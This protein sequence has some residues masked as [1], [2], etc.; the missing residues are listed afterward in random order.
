MSGAPG[1]A[2]LRV[3]RFTPLRPLKSL[4]YRSFHG[5]GCTPVAPFSKGIE[6]VV[7]GMKER[8]FYIDESGRRK[9]PCFRQCCDLAPLITQLNHHVPT[10]NRAT[11]AE[12]LATRT[13]SKRVVYERAKRDL[14]DKAAT[15]AGLAK[16][17]FFTKWESTIW[18]KKQVPRIVS[19]RDPR[20]NYLL[21]RYLLP[22][23]HHLYDAMGQLFMG[24]PVIAKGMTQEAK[25]EAIAAK[26]RP[27]WVAVGLDASRFDQTIGAELLK[28]EHMI[29]KSAYP[30]DRLLANLL[31]EQLRNKGTAYCRDG[32]VHADIG[33]MR[34]SGDQNTSLG[35]CMIS[36][37]LAK[38]YFLEHGFE[39]DVLNDGDDLIMF[40]HKSNLH[41]LQDLGDW[42]LQWGLRMKVEEP[43]YS[44]EQ[45]EFCQSKPVWT[46][47]GYKLVRNP[48]KAFNTD[49]SGGNRLESYDNYRVHLRS[50]GVCGLSM[51]AGIP[52]FQEFYA[53]GIHLGKTGKFT[54]D[55]AGLGYQH[56]IQV[57]AGFL[58][59]KQP[60]D[61]RTRESF[62]QAFGI[63]AGQQ[64]EI[65]DAI[66]KMV[67]GRPSVSTTITLETQPIIFNT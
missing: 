29:Y 24:E 48:R 41:H 13:G 12:F 46:P 44:P 59:R 56:E 33:A 49:Y 25:G 57:R 34:C 47:T 40:L 1:H 7:S 4:Y 54:S 27:G 19:P 5:L 36:C 37:L 17:S 52:L 18:S 61:P 20:Y 63:E 15:L 28:A 8:V 32:L 3:R 55:V 11:G 53:K 66:S 26:L 39:G 14:Q 35:N 16:L 2:K 9:P 62:A 60:I 50:V 45:V 21:G 6:N 10:C 23:E 42:Y 65:E 67:L 51:A 22:L 38:L 30:G 31:R 64:L 58:A 43:A